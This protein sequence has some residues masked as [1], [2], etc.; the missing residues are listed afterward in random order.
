MW[1]L[2]LFDLNDCIFYFSGVGKVGCDVILGLY[3]IC[4]IQFQLQVIDLNQFSLLVQCGDY[5]K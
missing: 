1:I 5:F 2:F 3:C 4:G